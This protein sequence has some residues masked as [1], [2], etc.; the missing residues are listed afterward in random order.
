[1][2]VCMDGGMGLLTFKVLLLCVE[3]I[4]ELLIRNKGGKCL[5]FQLGLKC[6]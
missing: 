6:G 3:K 1:M 4:A 5:Y 2:D